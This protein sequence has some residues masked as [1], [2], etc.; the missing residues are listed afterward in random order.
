M[1]VAHR[2]LDP[3][4]KLAFAGTVAVL[5]VAIPR[6]DSLAA[7]ALVLTLVVGLGRG[8]GLREWVGRLAPFKLLV[9]VI[10][11]L[12]AFFYGAGDVLWR[13]PLVPVAVTVGGIETSALIAARLLVV[14]S[15]ASWFAATTDPAEFEVALSSLGVPW[16]F[17]FVLSL[18]LRLVPELRARFR[19]IEEAQRARG[20]AVEGGPLARTRAR[21]PML[22]PFLASVVRYGFELSDALVVR[23]FDRADERTH[24]V[25]VAHGRADY[26]L[27]AAAALLAVG[28]V[29]AFVR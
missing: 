6:L 12:N 22:V 13:A 5:A 23:E 21:V 26:A 29:G 18:T 16:R 2:E 28:F 25:G 9:P 4:S 20:L 24:V 10:F 27:Y 11:V 15:A 7:L 17:A 8:L 3:R 19:T 14:A 1:T